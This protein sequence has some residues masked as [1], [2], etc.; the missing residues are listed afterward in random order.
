MA[1]F[2]DFIQLELPKRPFTSNDGVDGQI[3]VRSPNAEKPRE[4]V[5]T[6]PGDVLNAYTQ[7]EIDTLLAN[8]SDVGHGHNSDEILNTSSIDGVT[9]NDVLEYLDN[10]INV[11]G[12]VFIQDTEP[13]SYNDH[14]IW[15]S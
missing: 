11:S 8:K 1:S 13:A 3:L 5:W 7:T 6:N 14:T 2:N 15:I 12:H 4:L 10:N 9:I